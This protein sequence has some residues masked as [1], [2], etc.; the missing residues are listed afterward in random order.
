M[1]TR[2]ILLRILFISLALAAFF[3]AVGIMFSS[4]E[5]LW[6]IAGT[7]IATA[8]AALFL[9]PVGMMLEKASTRA[10]ANAGAAL[11]VVEYLLALLAIWEWWDDDLR[12]WCT[13]AILAACGL[14]AIAFVRMIHW[15]VTRLA[16]IAGLTF[17][18]V[19][20]F[21]TL[22]EIWFK[23]SWETGELAAYVVPYGLLIVVCLIGVG[24]DRQFWRLL[25]VAAAG[26]AYG[27]VAYARIHHLHGDAT[28]LIY[29]TAL[30]AV[31]AH[32]NV[33]LTVPLRPNQSWLRWA[34]ILAGVATAV[35]TC[36]TAAGE[37]HLQDDAVELPRRLA[38]ACG[39]VAGCGTLAMGVLARMNRRYLQAGS[40]PVTDLRD[41]TLI[42]PLC[43]R[44]QTIPLNAPSRCGGC[45]VQLQVRVEEPR[46]AVCGYS[47]MMLTSGVCPECGTP[48]PPAASRP[49]ATA[50]A[51]AT[52]QM[53]PPPPVQTAHTP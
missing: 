48:A 25:G 4:Y 8:V 30:A 14:P 29:I 51:D 7:S 36:I 26:L 45:N 15:R 31:I 41:I 21:M 16:G 32:A 5:G 42:C 50:S 10:A 6:R 22:L 19:V 49:S 40:T 9:L 3:G 44:K 24:T 38:G 1:P 37:Q 27:I 33:M 35:F 39:V 11:I 12:L 18:T 28:F 53:S 47:L 20:L 2:S 43:G 34:T 23:Y 52:A 17:A 46:C 13:F